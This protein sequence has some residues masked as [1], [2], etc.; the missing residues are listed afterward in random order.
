MRKT[1]VRI[2]GGAGRQTSHPALPGHKNRI[3]VSPQHRRG[4]TLI[5]LLV[6]VAIISILASML[7]PALQKAREKARQAVCISNLKQISML[8]FLYRQDYDG[9]FPLTWNGTREWYIAIGLDPSD[10][11][12]K[13][14]S[15]HYTGYYGN[16]WVQY[17]YTYG[18]INGVRRVTAPTEKALVSGGGYYETKAKIWYWAGPDHADESKT[19]WYFNQ[20][21]SGG[22]NI[23]W[24]DGHASWVR[25]GPGYQIDQEK[26]EWWTVP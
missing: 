13:C 5:E 8:C 15:N 16:D 14:P 3:N 12:L 19:D 17:S 21:H 18:F 24:C 11:L 10:Q 2:C 4:F 7:L 9:F 25:T 23:V 6:V 22:F 26:P 20:I 1:L